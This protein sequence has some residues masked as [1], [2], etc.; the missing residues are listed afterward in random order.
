MSEFDT[1][2]PS[3]RNIQNFIQDKN[4]VELK[5]VTD[6]LIV[7]KIVW[8]DANCICLMDHYEQPTIVWRQSIV[9]MKPK[10]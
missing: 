9:F 1:S 8:Q 10:P 7:G 4:E 2:L 6:D 5:L 3:I